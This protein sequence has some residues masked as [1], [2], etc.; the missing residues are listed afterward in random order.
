MYFELMETEISLFACPSGQAEVLI[1][2]LFGKNFRLIVTFTI[3]QD[4]NFYPRLGSSTSSMITVLKNTVE[5]LRFSIVSKF[6][7]CTSTKF[8]C[9]L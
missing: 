9:F 3:G 7:K 8:Q 1:I 5:L 2:A 4:L 6:V